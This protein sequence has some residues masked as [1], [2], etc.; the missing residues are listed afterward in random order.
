MGF[1][2]LGLDTEQAIERADSWYNAPPTV[3]FGR[4]WLHAPRRGHR[5]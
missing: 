4:P 2:Y 1:H 5:R 3:A